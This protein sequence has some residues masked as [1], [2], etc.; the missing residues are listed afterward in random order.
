MAIGGG[1]EEYSIGHDEIT[2]TGKNGSSNRDGDSN[3][4]NSGLVAAAA[5]APAGRTVA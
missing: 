1:D 4:S 5:V 3:R 2:D